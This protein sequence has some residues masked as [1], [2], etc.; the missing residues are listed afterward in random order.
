MCYV[1]T[2]L[3]RV[4]ANPGGPSWVRT[5]SGL[6]SL[7][8]MAGTFYLPLKLTLIFSLAAPVASASSFVPKIKPSRH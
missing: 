2:R 4:A 7:L 3:V 6:F 1:S 5:S 8:A